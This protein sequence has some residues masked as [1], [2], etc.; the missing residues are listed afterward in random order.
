MR[1]D[2]NGQLFL[3]FKI[4]SKL[5]EAMAQATPGDRK[6]YEDAQYLRVLPL[7]EERWIGK[8]IE[9]GIA[10]GEFEDLQRNI[11]SLM[12]RIAPQGRHSVSAMRIFT[13]DLTPAQQPASPPPRDPR[14]Y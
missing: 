4:D 5:R 10:P 14:D 12:T 11:I 2:P 9:G 3:G 13:V 1:L 7:G 8:V 6:F